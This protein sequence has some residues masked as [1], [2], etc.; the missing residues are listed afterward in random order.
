MNRGLNF[1]KPSGRAGKSRR[2]A[3]RAMK[4]RCLVRRAERTPRRQPGGRAWVVFDSVARKHLSVAGTDWADP[5]RVDELILGNPNLVHKADTLPQLAEKAG[6][7]VETFL[8]TI[9]RFNKAL[10][11]GTDPDFDRFNPRNPPTARVGL[12]AIPP[13]AVPP[14]YAAAVY[15][16][17]RKSMGGIA[18][19][20]ECRVLNPRRQPIPGSPRRRRGDR[21]QRTE[22]QG[23]PG[24][25][26]HWTIDSARPHPRPEP[27]QAG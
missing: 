18:V 2:K 3:V 8:A 11:D 20:L 14:F 16:M 6:W 26:L 5:K 4:R 23:R 15:P 1:V 22:R 9:A 27:R 10:V 24:R 25:N 13:V 17:T 21:L 7:P 12:P 19:D